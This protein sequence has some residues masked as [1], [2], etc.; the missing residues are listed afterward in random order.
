MRR[1][2][3]R[4]LVH[5]IRRTYSREENKF[6]FNISYETTVKLT[7]RA[8]VVAEAF[9]LGIDEAQKFTVLDAEL[10]I[11]PRDI[12]YISGDSGSGKSVLLRAIRK[13]LGDEAIDLSEVS[14]EVDKP[15]IE[16]LGA[17]VEEGLELLSK[18]GLNDAFLFLRSYNQ[19]SDGQKYRYRIAKLIESRK[20]WW[21]MD[22][23][24]AT[25]DRD[26][27]KIISFNL[28]KI[29]RQQGKAVLAATTHGDL[30]EDLK[31]SVHVHKRF[32]KE[33]T[34]EYFPN[35]PAEEC[36]LTKEMV[37]E[38]GCLS[39]WR[40]LSEFHYRSHHA[41]ASRKVYC[42]RRGVELC[43]VI[44]FTYPPPGCAGRNLV[45]PGRRSMKE[46]NLELSTISRIVIHPKYR[47]IGLGVKLIRE[48]LP[49][50][51]TPCVEMIAVM[52]KYNPFAE[53]AGMKKVLEQKPSEEAK[54]VADALSGL[55]FD[56]K[57]LGSQKHVS[58]KL[59]SLDLEQLES[60]KETFVKNDH[61]RFRRESAVNRH[62]PYGSAS[63][64]A[65]GVR[66][67]DMER[68]ARLVKITGM[69]LQTKVYLFW[70]ERHIRK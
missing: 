52:A 31:P 10:K 58:D 64:Y 17:T 11:G 2:S 32:G 41:G 35:R 13:D 19:L 26:T 46:L 56:L 63:A 14:I 25:L 42:L 15:L 61:P 12:V 37:I 48:T 6:T 23:F 1:R 8:L 62:M 4:F 59:Q 3:E 47:S 70:G 33:I 20:Q 60:L 34:V 18:V 40:R 39:D 69:L 51:D 36:S 49:R 53:K 54:Q 29:A 9:G 28:Q 16:T 43:G 55:G 24:A 45:L 57:L 22:E 66:N 50:G 67:A 38:E 21:L 30:L 27:A 5:K 65:E 7:P 44:V 68:V